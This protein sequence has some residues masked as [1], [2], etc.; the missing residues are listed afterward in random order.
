MNRERYEKAIKNFFFD[1]TPNKIYRESDI[2]ESCHIP[3]FLND[4]ER[5]KIAEWFD[6]TRS[7]FI[8]LPRTLDALFLS[9]VNI[10]ELK[11]RIRKALKNNSDGIDEYYRR[12]DIPLRIADAVDYT[13]SVVSDDL[14]D[15]LKSLEEE[16]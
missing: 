8:G 14:Y 9:D 10:D 1:R 11:E 4:E 12:E 16:K 7:I 15:L 3:G 13:F 2:M 5:S 6:E